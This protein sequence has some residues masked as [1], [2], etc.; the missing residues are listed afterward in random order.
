MAP[1]KVAI[2]KGSF[3]VKPRCGASA[4]T[5]TG[6]VG[7]PELEVDGA[8]GGAAVARWDVMVDH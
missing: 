7:I 3:A 1:N 8:R 4:S 5:S 6:R 2:E